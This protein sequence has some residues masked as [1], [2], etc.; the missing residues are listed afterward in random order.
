MKTRERQGIS[1]SGV[2]RHSEKPP[3]N[4]LVLGWLDRTGVRGNF[5]LWSERR[6][7]WTTHRG[8]R[9]RHQTRIL[10]PYLGTTN[11]IW[12]TGAAKG[13]EETGKGTVGLRKKPVIAQS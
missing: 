12:E 10:C 4:L 11:K 2:G 6:T 5:G 9:V 1:K 7:N 3:R 13:V 8:R